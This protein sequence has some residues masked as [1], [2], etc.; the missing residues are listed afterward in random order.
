[1]A[2]RGRGN[3]VF[4]DPEVS[5]VFFHSLKVGGTIDDARQKARVS[6]MNFDRE[7]KRSAKFR[8]KVRRLTVHA[9]MHHI[10]RVYNAEDKWQASAWWLERRHRNEFALNLPEGVDDEVRAIKIRRIVRTSQ[11]AIVEP[12][13]SIKGRNAKL[14]PAVTEAKNNN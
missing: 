2:K 9:K 6:K 4:K 1:M 7:F 10:E 5:K 13:V 12:T 14:T 11:P 8:A 3:R